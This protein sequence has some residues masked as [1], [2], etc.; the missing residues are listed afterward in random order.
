MWRSEIA[1]S[2]ITDKYQRYVWWVAWP[3]ILLA[4]FSGCARSCSA[5]AATTSQTVQQEIITYGSTAILAFLT[6]T[7]A[8]ADE[9]TA[10]FGDLTKP[11]SG[12]EGIPL[13]R[14]TVLASFASAKPFG[15]KENSTDWLVKLTAVTPEGPETWQLPVRI[16]GSA[17]RPT[18]LP[19]VVPGL[20]S[21]P[22]I[23]VN[24]AA[25]I[26]VKS[27]SAVATTLRDF[28][29][30]WMTGSGD[31]GRVADITRV[32]AFASSPFSRVR[33]IEAYAG[34]QIPQQPEGDLTAG[35]IVW[36]TNTQTVQLSY[37]LTLTASA[38]RW[39]VSNISAVPSVREEKANSPTTPAGS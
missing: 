30:A 15:G 33:L 6:A 28:F 14:R 35:V 32:P 4:V 29:S 1:R 13:P 27:D 16:F 39:V 23:T 5:P 12:Q 3:L 26:D 10:I 8:D 17:Y 24:A 20:A 34:G 7:P 21:G 31:L 37:T 38:G 22:P 19:G 18:Q 2:A 9:L 11:A 25:P 36:G